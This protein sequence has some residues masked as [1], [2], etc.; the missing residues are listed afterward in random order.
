MG[1]YSAISDTGNAIINLLKENLVPE[2]IQNEDT[3]GLCSPDDKGDMTLGI[4]LYDIKES[5]EVIDNTMINLNSKVQKYP[6]SYLTLSYMITAYSNGDV[7]FRSSEEQKIIG[8]V[9]QVFKDNPYLDSKTLNP[10]EKDNGNSIS[11]EL[12]SMPMEEKLRIWTV[13]NTAYKLSIFIKVSPIEIE[14]TKQKQVQRVVD[15]DFDIKE[16][17]F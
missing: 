6:S 2:V 17:E 8:R 12:L 5:E 9:I 3:I 15:I 1:M 11:I 16:K 14:S 13:P 7:R 10:L 4:F